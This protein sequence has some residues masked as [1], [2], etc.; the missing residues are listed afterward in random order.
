MGKS[1]LKIRGRDVSKTKDF[2]IVNSNDQ[3]NLVYTFGENI[4]KN[5]NKQSLNMNL[6]PI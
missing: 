5:V 4:H 6:I 3:K 1:I 2:K